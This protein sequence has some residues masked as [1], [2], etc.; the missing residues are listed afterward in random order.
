MTDS[1]IDVEGFKKKNILHIYQ[2]PNAA[3]H[4][5]GE[6]KG[7]KDIMN[8]ILANSKLPV[9]IVATMTP[10]ISTKEQIAANVNVERTFHSNF[11]KFPGSVPCHYLVE[12]IEPRL[13]GN[14]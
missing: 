4:P 10:K 14:G 9:R 8:R 5:E 13:H 3:D 12:K 2:I 6:L 7:L 1:D 11:D